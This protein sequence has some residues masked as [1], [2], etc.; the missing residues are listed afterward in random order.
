MLARTSEN[1]AQFIF[2][3]DELYKL[4]TELHYLE[5][6]ANQKSQFLPIFADI[7]VE[8]KEGE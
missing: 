5:T 6:Y 2:T 1:K 7:L 8:L 3:Y 4:A